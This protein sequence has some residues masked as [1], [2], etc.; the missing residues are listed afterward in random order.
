VSFSL[1][2]F[3]VSRILMQIKVKVRPG[4][5]LRF[6]GIC[7][8]CGQRATERLTLRKRNG[9]ITRLLDVPLCRT[10]DQA[11]RRRSILQEQ[12]QKLGW[13]GTGLILLLG[14][15]LVFLLL[16][17]DLGLGLRLLLALLAAGLGAAAVFTQ[18]RRWADQAALPE[19]KAIRQAARLDAFSWRTITLTFTNETFA[20]QFRQLN[21]PEVFT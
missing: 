18:S 2:T 4:E 20:E 11:R 16:P 9:R 12:R 8:H 7:V 3:H 19:S 14:L 13:L 21:Q 6:P 1:V 17:A 10:C 5:S 15:I